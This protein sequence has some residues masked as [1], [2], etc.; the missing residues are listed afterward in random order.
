MN[1]FQANLCLV[2]VTIFWSSE[3]LIYACIP[4]GVPSFA[5]VCVTSLAGAVLMFLPF[6]RR[7][8]DALRDGGWRF[9][10][11]GLGLAAINAAYSLHFIVGLRAFDT[12]ESAFVSCLGVVVMPAVMLALR[13]RVAP[14][15]WLSVALV[16]AGIVLALVPTF[17]AAQSRALFA[18]GVG[19]AL[20]S[21]SVII[22]AELVRRHDPVAVAILRKGFMG[23]FALAG[24]F[25]ADPRLFAGLPSSRALFAA[26]AVYAYLVIALSQILYVFAIRHVPA[27][28]ATVI[29][30]L[31]LVFTLIMGVLVPAGLITRIELSPRVIAGTALVVSGSLAQMLD[32]GGRRK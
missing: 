8:V 31:K 20:S 28:N 2:S 11:A 25:A 3:V 18:I 1:R 27:E 19:S 6:Y 21:L 14:Q 16:G 29:N 24:W 26:W 12:T 17:R 15:T 5:T 10:L 23:L 32:L 22:L 7:V 30:S 4:S 9:V 13:R